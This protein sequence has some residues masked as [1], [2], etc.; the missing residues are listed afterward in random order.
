MNTGELKGM[1]TDVDYDRGE[2]LSTTNTNAGIFVLNLIQQ[3]SGSWERIGK[4]VHLKSI[5]INGT[6]KF[7]YS[8]IT[9]SSNLLGSC[10][11][12]CVVWDKNPNSGTIPTFDTIFGKTSQAGGESTTYLDGLKY[13]NTGRFRVLRDWKIV[14]SP[15]TTP[16]TDGTGGDDNSI[17]AVY[18]FDE[19]VKLKNKVCVFSGQSDPMT[20][21]DISSGALYL[22]ARADVN[23]ADSLAEWAVENSVARLRYKE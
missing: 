9:T 13:D 12:M 16:F 1:D 3:G 23:T 5:R 10:M 11:R 21:A 7:R 18:Y 19:F 17:E 20:I 22:V 2:V 8:K 15:N 6:A 4:K 14:C